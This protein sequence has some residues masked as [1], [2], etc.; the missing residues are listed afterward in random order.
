MLPHF[1]GRR[2][3]KSSTSPA[4]RHKALLIGINYASP[5]EDNEQGYRQ[6]KGP[7]NDAKEVKEAL[8]GEVQTAAIP[9][10]RSTTQRDYSQISLTTRKRIFA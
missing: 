10:S 7:I 4:P 6:L 2:C 3:C 9:L 5:A 8:I 1:R